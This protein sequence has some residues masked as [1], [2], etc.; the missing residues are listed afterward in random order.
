VSSEENDI[1]TSIFTEQEVKAAI[2]QMEHNK[3]SNPDGFPAEFYQVFCKII[4]IDLM[5]LFHEFHKGDPPLFSLNFGIIT[6]LAKEKE[7]KQIQQ[8]RPICLSNVNFK[9]FT[10]AMT[11]RIALVAQKI[12]QPS[13]TTFMRGR[14]I[15]DGR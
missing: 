6:L 14:N 11:N 10:K 12:I 8:F 1:L 4:K 7:A 3:A 15:M 13:Q 2:F 9:I 5:A